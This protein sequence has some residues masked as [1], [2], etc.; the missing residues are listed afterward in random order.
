[1]KR[2]SNAD[3]EEE[4]RINFEYA[5]E[6]RS[7]VEEQFD[8]NVHQKRIFGAQFD[9]KTKKRLNFHQNS[10]YIKVDETPS[11]RCEMFQNFKI[12]LQF[13][14]DQNIHLLLGG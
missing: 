1:M 14:F 13:I 10:C 2:A 5:Q 6:R 8:E 7:T 3:D 9:Q 12:C 11:K 4:A